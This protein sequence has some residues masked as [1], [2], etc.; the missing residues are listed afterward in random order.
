MEYENQ[1]PVTRRKRIARRR[2]LR[3]RKSNKEERD[4]RA[5]ASTGT[6]DRFSIVQGQ[7]GEQGNT[8]ERRNTMPLA[9]PGEKN[10]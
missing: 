6:A 3:L 10:T 2:N 7:N 4:R 1:E 5:S 8:T 9:T